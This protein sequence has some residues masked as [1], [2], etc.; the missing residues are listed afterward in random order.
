MEI[1]EQPGPNLDLLASDN[2]M[3]P[4]LVKILCCFILMQNT[5]KRDGIGGG[6]IFGALFG[7]YRMLP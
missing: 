4:S 1:R 7:Q 6:G 3:L 2:W 5:E